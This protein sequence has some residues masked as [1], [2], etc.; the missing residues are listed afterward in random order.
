[1]FT[2]D[3]VGG[4]LWPSISSADL[5]A[6]MNV[7]I[8]FMSKVRMQFASVGTCDDDGYRQNRS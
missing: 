8:G 4:Q 7:S 5:L 2:A 1:M 6:G 3:G